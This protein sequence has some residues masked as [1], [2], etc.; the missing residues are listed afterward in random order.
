MSFEPDPPPAPALPRRRTVSR[1]R[2][3]SLAGGSLFVAASAAGSVALITRRRTRPP[4][5]AASPSAIVT[6]APGDEE[7]WPP[8]LLGLS[9]DAPTRFTF[10][11]AEGV[12][13]SEVE[14]MREAGDLARDFYRREAGYY[15]TGR[16][17]IRLDFTRQDGPLGQSGGQDVTIFV[18]H[19][20]WPRLSRPA[21]I[22]VFCH[23]V[24]HLYQWQLARGGHP[25]PV[26]LIEGGAEYASTSALIDAGLRTRAAATLRALS[27]VRTYP[28]PHIASASRAQE[29]GVYPLG[30]LAIDQLVGD[31]GV[32]LL[33]TYFRRLRDERQSEAFA[34]TFGESR[35]A[36]EA[37]FE[38]WREEH[39]IGA[40]G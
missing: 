12:P 20:G 29:A 4:F 28:Q 17:G 15:L 21:R 16:P 25:R 9:A 24:F 3:L 36:F 38:A 35:E 19:R 27:F 5:V 34:H 26:Y 22:G 1:R 2:V 33:A 11:V 6:P 10:R 30:E 37:R 8:P 32:A 23:E 40:R 39:G 7:E 13:E 31:G 18:G 14:L